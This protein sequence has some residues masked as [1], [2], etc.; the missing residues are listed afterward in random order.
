MTRS[1]RFISEHRAVFGVT[2]L[3]RVLGVRRP[4]FYEWL[5][6]TPTRAERAEADERLAA[7]IGEVHARHRGAYGRPRIVATLRR[8]G[9]RV[10]HKR[11][12]RVM[13]EHGVVGLTRRRRRS[14]TRPD[15]VAA[16]VPDLI[17]RDFTAP[18]PGRRL[19]GDIN[20]LPT[21]E[22]WLYLATVIDL[23]SRE[24]I[25]HAM[26]D[27][28]RADLVR[29]ALNLAVKRGLISDDA[30]FHADR[31]SQ[32]EFNWSSQHFD[33]GGVGWDG[34][35]S[36]CR[37]HRAELDASGLRIGRCGRRCAHPG[38]R[39]RRGRFSGTSGA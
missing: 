29:D 15:A 22:G 32:G 25:G 18:A 26:A 27:H 30:I 21:R 17:G 19:V 11:V 5:A 2:R 38:G 13:R 6:A 28:M 10:N 8:R 35:G 24:V 12:G 34:R 14:L 16:P 37:R 36:R 20:Y 23:H 39:S 31:G 9:R 1:Y 33:D 7:E 4:G 3:C